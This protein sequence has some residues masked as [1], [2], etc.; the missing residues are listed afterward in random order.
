VGVL[1]YC[2]ERACFQRVCAGEALLDGDQD[3]MDLDVDGATEGGALTAVPW[4][5]ARPWCVPCGV[6]WLCASLWFSVL[7]EGKCLCP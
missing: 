5:C 4:L 2:C 6:S 7:C 3:A 1:G